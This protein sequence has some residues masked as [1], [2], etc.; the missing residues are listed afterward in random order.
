MLNASLNWASILGLGLILIWI[1]LYLISLIHVDW[2]TRREVEH[3]KKAPEWVVF[4]VT[5]C[6]RAFCLPFLAGILFFQGWRLDPILQFGI[7]LLVAGVIAEASKSSLSDHEQNRQLASAYRLETDRSRTSAMTL[8]VQDRVWLWAVLH[9]TVPLVSF[10]YAL[11]RRTITPFLWDIIVRMIVVVLSNGL[12]YLL[13]VLLGG[14]PPD[15]AFSSVNPWLIVAF[16][17]VLLVLNWLLAVLAARH[18]I[19]KAKTFAQLKLGMQSW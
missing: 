8:R 6:G 12:V 5:F 15:S 2:L 14:W 19:M 7:F 17:F 10:Y 11:T 18:G 1:P 13:V 16:G 9:A 4:A 3:R